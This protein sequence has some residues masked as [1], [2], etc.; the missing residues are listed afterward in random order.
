M[1]KFGKIFAVLVSGFAMFFVGCASNET[2]DVK[3]RKAALAALEPV[4]T[5]P[6]KRPD[7]IDVVPITKKE[8]AFTGI[9]NNF[10]TDVEAR[11]D[12]MKNGRNQLVSYYGTMV[13]DKSRELSATYG[14]SSDILDPQKAGQELREYLAE[15]V[16]K[17]LPGKEFYTEMYLNENNKPY[18][19]VYVLMTI[20][21][22]DADRAMKEFNQNKANEYQKKAEAEKD[23]EKR[24]QFEKV[25][26]IFGGDLQ[27]SLVD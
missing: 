4:K 15:G 19:R 17:N 3:V 25:R 6:A 14:I 13:S 24:K 5:I 8:L 20:S 22:E 21:K 12:A 27:S 18:Y 26:D 23:A 10:A 1:K 11:N 16:A 7:W 2:D 9:S